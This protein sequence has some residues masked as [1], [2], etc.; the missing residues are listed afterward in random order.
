MLT[1]HS[2]QGKSSLGAV[3][4]APVV[5][6]LCAG[7]ALFVRSGFGEEFVLQLSLVVAPFFYDREI[8]KQ[9]DC[10]KEYELAPRL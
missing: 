9:L 6:Y 8:K 10:F 3:N 1:M 5:I 4:F 2:L 7:F